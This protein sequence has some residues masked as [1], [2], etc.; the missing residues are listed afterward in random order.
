MLETL[1]T[2]LK[3]RLVC[4]KGS[5]SRYLLEIYKEKENEEE[6]IDVYELADFEFVFVDPKLKNYGAN[7]RETA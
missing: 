2:P 5:K 7:N 6:V 4:E 3:G 1:E